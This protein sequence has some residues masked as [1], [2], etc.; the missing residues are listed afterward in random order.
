MFLYVFYDFFN[1]F[2]R[3][4]QLYSC[5]VLYMC[6]YVFFDFV[7][8][9]ATLAVFNFVTVPC[10]FSFMSENHFSGRK[11]PGTDNV[12]EK[13]SY[14]KTKKVLQGN[15]HFIWIIAKSRWTR[16]AICQSNIFFYDFSIPGLPDF[17]RPEREIT[18]RR[19]SHR[20]RGRPKR[21]NEDFPGQSLS[22][23]KYT[24]FI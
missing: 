5:H 4:Q 18:S 23:L 13:G 24:F 21:G 1:F 3:G 6:F 10:L 20:S 9:R 8:K 7:N 16:I 19:Q 17:W 15:S 14:E 11:A 12:S 22:S 2:T